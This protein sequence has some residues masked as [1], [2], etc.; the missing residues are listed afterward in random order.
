MSYFSIPYTLASKLW[1]IPENIVSAIF[2]ATSELF[3]RNQK[4]TLRELHLRS[5]KYIMMGV[6]PIT[7]LL[8]IFAKEILGLWV[9]PDFAAKSAFPLRMLALATLISSS[10][11]T[12]VTAAKGAGRPDIPAKVQVLQAVINVIFCLL[13]IPRWGINGAAVAW[14]IHHIVGIPVIIW[15]TN[16]QVLKMP[17]LDFIKGGLGMPLAVGGMTPCLLIP[18]RSLMSS[19]T[20][21]LGLFVS[22]GIVY[23]IVTY[24]AVLDVK[25]RSSASSYLHQ[26]RR[27]S[28]PIHSLKARLNGSKD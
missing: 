16:R 18:F 2:P 3:A 22:I 9:G 28:F 23:A 8:M 10:A 11:W 1:L 15:I 17:N 21:L 20:T 5:T 7:A 24:F 27:N 26:L 4:T 19:L 6:V 12:S 13:L 25:D 14:L